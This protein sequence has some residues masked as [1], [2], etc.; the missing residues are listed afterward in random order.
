MCGY[1]HVIPIMSFLRNRALIPIL[2]GEKLGTGL[3][4]AIFLSW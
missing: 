3:S 2:L 1:T 4:L